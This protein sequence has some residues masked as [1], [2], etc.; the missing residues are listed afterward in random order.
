MPRIKVK[1]Q[2]PKNMTQVF[3]KVIDFYG[4]FS[5][6]SLGQLAEIYHKDVVFE[7][8]IAKIDG[9]E[10]VKM[11]FEATMQ[12]LKH[13]EF[14]I[15]RSQNGGVLSYL[16]WNMHY[17]HPRLR[18]GRSLTLSGISVLQA[19]EKVIS[20]RDYYDMGQ[21]LYENVPILGS[22]TK[23]LKNNLSRKA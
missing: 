9:L 15:I 10:A 14:E 7:D 20:H 13:C 8:P 6:E 1:I 21:M 5:Q 12:G 16:E 2:K 11:H 22:V 23:V 4:S 18:S 3:E 17:S 19:E